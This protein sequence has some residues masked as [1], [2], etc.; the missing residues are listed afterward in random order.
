MRLLGCQ[1]R[2]S[3]ACQQHKQCNIAGGLGLGK[4]VFLKCRLLHN[5]EHCTGVN[6]NTRMT[7][8]EGTE[9]G[10]LKTRQLE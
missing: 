10:H 1:A 3:R 4:K 7:P 2:G 8:G 9:K 5:R 6:F